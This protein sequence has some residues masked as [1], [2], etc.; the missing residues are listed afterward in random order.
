[1]KVVLL[2]KN[3]RISIVLFI[4]FLSLH[5]SASSQ[6]V[7]SLLYPHN[8]ETTT[9]TTIKFSWNKD[10]YHSVQYE[11][12]LSTDTNF[13]T[14]LY[15]ISTN[16]NWYT[17]PA[18]VG[19][20]QKHF[21]RVRSVLNSVTSPWSTTRS[22]LLFNPNA[23]V[24]LTLW[25]DPN[26]SLTL[27]GVN[28]QSMN[29]ISNNL[30]NA[31]QL[32]ATQQPF[33]VNSDSLINNKAILRFDGVN[34]FLEI[35]DNYTVDFVDQFSI[36]VIVKPS[37]IA[38]NK[39]II[40][41]WDYNTQGSWGFQSDFN[42]PD[43]LMYAPASIL[44][45]A[46]ASK[47]ITTNA[48]MLIN[49]PALLNLVF[50]GNLASKVKYYKNFTALNIST[51]APIPSV[52]PNS[53]ATLK[54]A[55]WGGIL[56]RYYQGDIGEILIYN[57]EL[58]LPNKSLVDSY[59]RYKYAPPVSLGKDTIM[60]SNSLCAVFQLKA[61]SKYA[62]Y[63]WSNGTTAS[64]L[65]VNKPG[66]YWLS[67]TDF[68]GNITV[69]SIIIYPP[70]QDNFSQTSGILCAGNSIQLQTS[71]PPANYTFLWQN[72]ATTSNFNIT[73]AGS[74][75]LKITDAA[76]CFIRTDTLIITVDNYP[77]SSN[78]GADTNLCV[79]NLIALQIG[80]QETISYEWNGTSTIAQSP[81]WVVDTTGNYF[82]ETVNING[83]VAQDTIHI[84][85]IGQAPL[86]NFSFQNQCFGLPNQF[87]DA[88]IGLPNDPVSTWQ[89]DFGNGDEDD[90][91]NPN[92]TYAAPGLYSVQLYAES[93]GG[94][95]AFHTELLEI[96]QLPLA[97]FTHL[98]NCEGQSVNFTNTSVDGNA[99]IST[100][101]WNFDQQGTNSSTLANPSC[102]F[103]NAGIYQVA[104]EVSDTNGCTDTVNIS[105]DILASPSASFTV[106]NA[107]EEVNVI[108]QNNSTIVSP[109]SLVN[110]YWV[111]GDGTFANNPSISKQ[112]DNYGNYSILL[113][114]TASNGC[115]DSTQQNITI[116]PNPQL[117]WEIGP[118]CQFTYT[119][120]TNTSTVPVGS[121]SSTDW[122]VN[123]QFPYT[124][125]SATYPFLT[126]GIQ[127]LNLSTTSDQ[128]CISDTLIL[129]N[130]A[131]P[132]QANF[133]VV[134]SDLVAGISST[135]INNSIGGN[136]YLWELGDGVSSLEENVIH[137][138][139]NTEIGNTV[140]VSLQVSNDLGCLD[141]LDQNYTI[142]APHFDLALS[143]LFCQDI[144]SY[145]TI[146]CELKN[147][148]S[149]AIT[150]ANVV[151]SLLNGLPIMENWQGS[152]A[153]GESTI[154]IFQSH[155]A[156]Y[157]ATQDNYIS[158]V[159][160][161]GEGFN[162]LNLLDEE[163]A[164]NTSCRNVE[165]DGVILLP[166]YPNPGN[167][168]LEVN[169]FVP[170]AQDFELGLYDIQGRLIYKYSE[171]EV[172]TD[173]V[174]LINIPTQ[175]LSSGSYLLRLS[176][177]TGTQIRKWVKE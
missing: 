154:Y 21:W 147:Q 116:H 176:D 145:W 82:V 130:V 164:N 78:L 46:G 117:A 4:G 153:P 113:V 49:K 86:V 31:N 134:P 77:F 129:V 26:N 52:I 69:D 56:T 160:V 119:E 32:S 72:G 85:I 115:V 151:A 23:I 149:I 30:N 128:G 100:Y 140:T 135:F 80:A 13:T 29:D 170:Q 166:L 38:T 15:N 61:Q 42:T 34:D 22:F 132:L 137:S 99:P 79:D 159:C 158:Y 48:D 136:S 54:I 92:Y 14:L 5:F 127:Y 167:D 94:C 123:L 175:E 83:C 143:N 59:L 3:M 162:A 118:A 91:E 107:C 102:L 67:A 97:S 66:T 62:A 65:I 111:Y 68:L 125:S 150:Q 75:Y 177:V 19:V 174:K 74:Y 142:G 144:E 168:F 89:W 44:M 141:T 39:A 71:Y 105:V 33:L 55:K 95:G 81:F 88:S 50:N 20:G 25:L 37:V 146:G 47:V 148:G 64:K 43:E 10:Y 35:A 76:G 121:I 133:T 28:V 8:N 24:G 114:E 7:P 70:Y 126:A 11:F 152:L 51:V 112:Y 161:E 16:Y 101:L 110:H 138:Y 87:N 93:A 120:F 45:D 63:L 169:V 171:N 104:L 139:S 1:M 36:H 156:A 165:N 109:F 96:H 155:P 173:A 124:S 58:S 84:T 60:P 157:I 106:N 27:N 53:S 90:E 98:G 131:G 12:Q 40:V 172:I 18:L 9:S 122:L 73:Q 17:P 108:I 103:M 163:L 41:K 2:L 6:F 57:N